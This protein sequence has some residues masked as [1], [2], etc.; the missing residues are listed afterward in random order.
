M[1]CSQPD[2]FAIHAKIIQ[3]ADE[4]RQRERE[5][6]KKTASIQSIYVKYHLV[7]VHWTETPFKCQSS[8][9]FNTILCESANGFNGGAFTFELLSVKLNHFHS[10]IRLFGFV[11]FDEKNTNYFN[12]RYSDNR[13]K[14]DS[15][16]SNSAH[17]VCECK[18]TEREQ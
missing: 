18:T 10:T 5:G 12:N 4:E 8:M 14:I 2:E 1:A 7:C 16:I 3:I 6:E 17:F 13:F 11:A 9:N 15:L